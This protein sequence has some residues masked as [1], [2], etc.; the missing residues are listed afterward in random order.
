MSDRPIIAVTCPK[1]HGEGEVDWR[2]NY[3]EGGFV[4]AEPLG[5]RMEVCDRCLG[6]GEVPAFG[7]LGGS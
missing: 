4:T 7:S 3:Y 5:V 2:D 1:C 6:V